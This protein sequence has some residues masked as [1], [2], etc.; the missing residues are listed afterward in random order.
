MEERIMKQ[1]FLLITVLGMAGFSN[2]TYSQSEIVEVPVERVFLPAKGFD[3]NDTVE[4][5][6]DGNLPNS[7]YSLEKQ[8]VQIFEAEKIIRVRQF[9]VKRTEGKCAGREERQSPQQATPVPFTDVVTLGRLAAAAEYKIEYFPTLAQ[10]KFRSFEVQVAPTLPNSTSYPED[11]EP[12][13]MITQIRVED[14]V[15]AGSDVIVELQGVLNNSCYHLNEASLTPKI[16]NDVLVIQPTVTVDQD[17]ICLM[18]L[19]PFKKPVRVGALDAN[20]YLLH[21]RSMQGK[22]KNQVFS[23]VNP[24]PASRRH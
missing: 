17:A 5:V 15:Q 1:R 13:A 14:I 23:V 2:K 7:C 6:V 10:S 9:A 8:K 20:R 16:L 21:V 22:S 19:T 12:Y 4:L 3:D 18:V 24:A 11:S